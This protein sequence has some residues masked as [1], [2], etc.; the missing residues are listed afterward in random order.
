MIEKD[1]KRQEERRLLLGFNKSIIPGLTGPGG[2]GGSVPKG[3]C[4][5]V[6]NTYLSEG[7]SEAVLLFHR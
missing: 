7:F 2:A 1:K 4:E 6:E 3:V 5:S